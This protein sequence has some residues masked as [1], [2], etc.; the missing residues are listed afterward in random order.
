MQIEKLKMNNNDVLHGLLAK[1]IELNA[2]ALE[3]ENKAGKDEVF[4]IMGGAGFE[5]ASFNSSGRKARTLRKE[6]NSMIGKKKIIDLGEVT[7]A[8]KATIFES[9]GENVFGIDIIKQG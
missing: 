2:D 6:L 9:F 3:I 8:L 5:I 1:A 4:A 7:Y